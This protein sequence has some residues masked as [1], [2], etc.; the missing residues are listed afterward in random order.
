[1]EKLSDEFIAFLQ[2]YEDGIDDNKV[3]E[4]FQSRHE[5]LSATINQLLAQ[6]RLQLFTQG[7]VLVYKLISE[8]KA[9]KFEGLGYVPLTL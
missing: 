6:N 8:D 3:K 7:D 5:Q 4:H 1:M 2:Q 9:V